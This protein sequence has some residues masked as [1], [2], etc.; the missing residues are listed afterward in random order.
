MLVGEGDEIQVGSE[1]EGEENEDEGECE[2]NMETPPPPP[3]PR[4][5]FRLGKGNKG[6]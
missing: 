5:I 4:S 3:P 6:V 1:E 2:G